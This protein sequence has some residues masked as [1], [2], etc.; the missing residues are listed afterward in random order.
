MLLFLSGCGTHY[1]PIKIDPAPLDVPDAGLVQPCD[2]ADSDPVTNGA[3]ANELAHA[4]RQ[5][6][7]CA[8]RMDGVGKWRV[9]A[10]ARAKN[11]K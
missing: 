2:R 9:D 3:L 11:P 4:R 1:A 8:D 6:N 7:D 10:L 5:R